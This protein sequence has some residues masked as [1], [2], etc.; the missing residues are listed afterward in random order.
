M[1]V[2]N[3]LLILDHYECSMLGILMNNYPWSLYGNLAEFYKLIRIMFKL[4]IH[5]EFEDNLTMVYL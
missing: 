4:V 5:I 2:M 1:N 3:L